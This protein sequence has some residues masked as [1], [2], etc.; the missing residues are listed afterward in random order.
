MSKYGK[1]LG[2]PVG[3]VNGK[4]TKL[5]RLIKPPGQA[6]MRAA[7]T[8]AQKITPTQERYLRMR[9]RGFEPE[10]SV[11]IMDEEDGVTRS[12][13]S[14]RG[15]WQ[16]LE[17][18]T[19]QFQD[20]FA[21]PERMNDV[22]FDAYEN[23][24]LERIVLYPKDSASFSLTALR[25]MRKKRERERTRDH[26]SLLAWF[27][28]TME[29]LKRLATIEAWTNVGTSGGSLGAEESVL[30][31]AA[32]SQGETPRT[33]KSGVA[34]ILGTLSMVLQGEE[35]LIQRLRDSVKQLSGTSESPAA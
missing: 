14:L 2:R 4:R 34:A 32:G 33:T 26:A 8:P 17:A 24:V 35:V 20:T 5:L 1:L 22:E 28:E 7:N 12:A 21:A 30:S 23:R 18:S 10:R 9:L 25:E 3:S 19:K 13:A 6:P 29:D 31:H 11:Q 27:D 16:E 15:K